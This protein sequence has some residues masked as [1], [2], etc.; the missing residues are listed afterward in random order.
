VCLEFGYNR[1][2]IQIYDNTHER[3]V[4]LTID[5]NKT[6]KGNYFIRSFPDAVGLNT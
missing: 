6:L 4:S 3:I 2:L 1:D 5:S